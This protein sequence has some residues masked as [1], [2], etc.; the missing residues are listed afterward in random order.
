VFGRL[1]ADNELIALRA[2]GVSV[3]RVCVSLC[4]VAIIC[5]LICLWLNVQVAPAAQ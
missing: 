2:N 3:P 5:T 1:S 4:G